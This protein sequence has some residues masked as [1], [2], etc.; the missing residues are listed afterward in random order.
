MSIFGKLWY[1]LYSLPKAFWGFYAFGFLVVYFLIATFF[2]SFKPSLGV[3]GYLLGLVV[4]WTYVTIASVGVWRSAGA[5]F[6][7]PI[8]LDRMWAIAARCVV[9][10][11]TLGFVWNLVKTF[12]LLAKE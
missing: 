1:G 8:W 2:L 7:E 5:K 6:R 4:L 12:G 10:I 11:V 9:I 3:S